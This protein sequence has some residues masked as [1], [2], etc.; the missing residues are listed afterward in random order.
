MPVGAGPTIGAID[1]FAIVEKL[2]AKWAIPMHYRTA[3]TN[4]LEPADA[5]VAH[6]GDRVSRVDSAFELDGLEPGVVMPA[7]P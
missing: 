7:A 1:A 6:F 2:S 5:F 4:F 3:R